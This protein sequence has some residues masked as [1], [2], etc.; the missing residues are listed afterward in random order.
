MKKVSIAFCAGLLLSAPA[1]AEREYALEYSEQE[2]A[3]SEGVRELHARIVRTAK[4]YCPSYAETR[5]MRET[6][7]CVDDVVTDLVERVNHADLS[8]LHQGRDKVR[9]AQRKDDA[10][11]RS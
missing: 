9:V 1:F 10:Q 7:A 2:L 3:T 11:D 4:D 5:Q 6:A 8:A